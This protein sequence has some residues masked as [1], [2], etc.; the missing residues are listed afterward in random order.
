MSNLKATAPSTQTCYPQIHFHLHPRCLQ[1]NLV[2]VT[3]WIQFHPNQWCLHHKKTC[4]NH[5]LCTNHTISSPTTADS[6]TTPAVVTTIVAYALSPGQ[7]VQGLYEY[8][9][10]TGMKQWIEATKPSDDKPYNGSSKGLS[11]FLR[12]LSGRARDLGWRSITKVQGHAIFTKYGLLTVQDVQ[13]TSEVRFQ[14]CRRQSH[15]T[16]CSSLVT[17][18]VLLDE[19]LLCQVFEK[20]TN[21]SDDHMFSST[22]GEVSEY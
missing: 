3:S 10:N 11:H 8:L 19:P 18:D 15:H 22:C 6:Q 2:P 4:P 20:V 5:Q 9:T 16:R 17:N 12:M 13:S 14:L 21:S 7:A 1:P